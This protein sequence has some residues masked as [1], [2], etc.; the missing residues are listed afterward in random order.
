[1]FNTSET[2]WRDRRRRNDVVNRTDGDDVFAGSV[3]HPFDAQT[4]NGRKNNEEQ[5]V[6]QL[7][8]SKCQQVK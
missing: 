5:E 2:P 6:D 7:K 4:E 8:C 3:V 1:L